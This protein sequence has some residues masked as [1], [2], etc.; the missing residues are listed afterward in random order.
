[1]PFFSGLFLKKVLT[2]IERRKLL[3]KKLYELWNQKNQKN[4]HLLVLDRSLLV[5]SNF[6]ILDLNDEY[7]DNTILY[8]Y[9]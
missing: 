3:L 5:P 1:M 8:V 9:K 7:Q 2:Q 4:G 6:K